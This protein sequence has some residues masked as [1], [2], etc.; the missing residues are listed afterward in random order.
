MAEE[1]F[2]QVLIDALNKYDSKKK[3]YG[4]SWKYMQPYRL[5]ERLKEEYLEWYKTNKSKQE[6][7]DELLDIINCALMIAVRNRQGD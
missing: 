2:R 4:D 1:E 7:Y 5:R 6:E 3:E